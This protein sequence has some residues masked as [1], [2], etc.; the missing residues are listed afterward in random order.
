MT[1]KWPR[2]FE[3]IRGFGWLMLVSVAFFLVAMILPEE[4]RKWPEV[5]GVLFLLPLFLY[6]YVVVI[7]HW[8][9]RYQ[10]KHSDLWGALLLIETSGWLKVIYLFRHIFPDMKRTPREGN[11]N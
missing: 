5:F 6:T 9:E 4:Q 11:H 2:R 1:D 10:G 3:L 7:W 8:K